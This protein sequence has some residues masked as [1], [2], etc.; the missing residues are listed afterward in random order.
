MNDRERLIKLIMSADCVSGF[1]GS[2]ADHLI[3]NGVTIQKQGRWKERYVKLTSC[4]DDVDIIYI[5]SECEAHN[6]DESPYCPNCGAKM[7]G[8]RKEN[9]R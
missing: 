9:D 7:D 2:L 1:A 5:C 3:A 8:E 6:F 4:E